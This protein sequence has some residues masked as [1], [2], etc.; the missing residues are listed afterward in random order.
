MTAPKR[1]RTPAERAEYAKICGLLGEVS[2]SLDRLE[3]LARDRRAE[4]GGMVGSA[5]E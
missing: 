2:D 3:E 4:A 5:R 1:E